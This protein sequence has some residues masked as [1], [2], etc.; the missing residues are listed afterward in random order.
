M[1]TGCGVTY[2]SSAVA[3]NGIGAHFIGHGKEAQAV[4]GIPRSFN[5]L[6]AI[7]GSD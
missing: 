3:E 4:W 6:A 7:L 5:H 2:Y 1:L